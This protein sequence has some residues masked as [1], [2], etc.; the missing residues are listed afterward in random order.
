MSSDDLCFLQLL[1]TDAI[2]NLPYAYLQMIHRSSLPAVR[3][4]TEG[5]GQKDGDM[6]GN[7]KNAR[8]DDTHALSEIS[9]KEKNFT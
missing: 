4:R 3:P 8:E 9:L 2:G 7:N 5:T 1:Q 6:A